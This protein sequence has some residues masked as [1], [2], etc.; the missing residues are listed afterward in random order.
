M[1]KPDQN[2]ILKSHDLKKILLECK[3]YDIFQNVKISED[4]LKHMDYHFQRYPSQIATISNKA[5]NQNDVIGNSIDWV[6]YYD[7]LMVQLDLGL[8]ELTSDN[9]I[10]I[11]YH[12]IQTLGT[13]YARDILN[14]NAA[15]LFYFER[16]SDLIRKNLPE[17]IELQNQVKKNISRGSL[18]YWD[19]NDKK[20]TN[21]GIEK[22]KN[23]YSANNFKLPKWKIENGQL[24]AII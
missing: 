11:F 10:S 4:F 5:Q 23:K 6:Y 17:K 13:R 21:E 9:K 12:T 18:F 8:L 2:K 16:Y 19:V 22:I 7:D 20:I 24:I 3:K 15:A 1:D 14:K